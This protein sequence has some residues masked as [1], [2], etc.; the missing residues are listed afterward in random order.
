MVPIATGDAE[1]FLDDGATPP[2]GSLQRSLES[3]LA[4]TSGA[5]TLGSHASRTSRLER[6]HNQ[7]RLEK[8]M[9]SNYAGRF[10]LT[11]FSPSC[12]FAKLPATLLAFCS[13]HPNHT[14]P[15]C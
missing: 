3:K 14:L 13:L 2:A 9:R 4:A 10:H 8:R 5:L 11:S 6:T 15:P 12:T 1:W 7:H